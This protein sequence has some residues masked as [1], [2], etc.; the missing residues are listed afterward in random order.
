M[1]QT[2]GVVPNHGRLHGLP[3]IRRVAPA[4][5]HDGLRPGDGVPKRNAEQCLDPVSW[6]QLVSAS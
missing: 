2:P 1:R 3:P 4:K 5:L 6:C